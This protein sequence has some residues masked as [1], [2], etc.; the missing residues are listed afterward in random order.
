MKPITFFNQ[1][2]ERKALFQASDQDSIKNIF[3]ILL[4]TQP[5]NNL[6]GP[7]MLPE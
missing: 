3:N 4:Y 5:Q 6:R 1:K 7:S 2:F